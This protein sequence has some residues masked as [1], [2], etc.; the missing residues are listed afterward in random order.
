MSLEILLNTWNIPVIA[1]TV[2]KS[3]NILASGTKN[4]DEPN[5]PIVPMISLNNAKIPNS[6]IFM[7]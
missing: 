2:L 6:K 7:S 3:K 4:T 5:P 1:S